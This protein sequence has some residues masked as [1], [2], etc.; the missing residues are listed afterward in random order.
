MSSF[1]KKVLVDQAELDRMQQRQ[2][3]DYSPELH[4]LARLQT[5]IAETLARKDIPDEK[6]LELLYSYQSRFDKL[7]R[8]TGV[9]SSNSSRMLVSA[10]S[11]GGGAPRT[12][13]SGK[14]IFRRAEP[15]VG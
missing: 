11:I 3:K 1:V 14:P 13:V 4:S 2:I 7:Q 12:I 15:V 9:L 6:K 8:E 5:L 10:S